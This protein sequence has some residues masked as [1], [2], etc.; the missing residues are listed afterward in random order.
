MGVWCG[1][2]AVDGNDEFFFFQAARLKSG[3]AFCL[4][5]RARYLSLSLSLSALSYLDRDDA[6]RV[7]LRPLDV[8][9][10]LGWE[11]KGNQRVREGECVDSVVGRRR[12]RAGALPLCVARAATLAPYPTVPCTPGAH[13]HPPPLSR[14]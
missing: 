11:R 1:G 3:G 2:K 5:E 12:R 6:A 7:V 8:F 9:L 14:M 4:A 10:G 13:A